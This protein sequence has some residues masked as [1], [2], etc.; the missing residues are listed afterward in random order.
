MATWVWIVIIVVALLV[1]AGVIFGIRRAR[2]RQLESKRQEAAELRGTAAAQARRA[3]ER[4]ALA[5]ETAKQAEED[6][7]RA[8][9]ASR[10]AAE[11]DPDREDE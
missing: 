11:V 5:R 2:E 1:V 9:E 10:R 8:E 3:D 7:S 6:R 4:E